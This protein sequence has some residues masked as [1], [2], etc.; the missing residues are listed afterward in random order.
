MQILF[1]VAADKRLQPACA[2]HTVP[3]RLRLLEATC[4]LALHIHLFILPLHSLSHPDQQIRE[5]SSKK[6]LETLLNEFQS[7]FSITSETFIAV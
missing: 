4:A 6:Y 3:D 5:P 2:R 1:A 7:H